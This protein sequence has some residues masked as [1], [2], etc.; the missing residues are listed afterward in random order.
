MTKTQTFEFIESDPG[1]TTRKKRAR[2]RRAELGQFMTSAEIAGF[3]ADMF[4]P[5]VGE[6][7]LLMP[8]PDRRL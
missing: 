4:S 3:M 2:S 5:P 6:I 8:V 7:T 1:E